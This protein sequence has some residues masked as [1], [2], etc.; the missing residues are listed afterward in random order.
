M[1]CKTLIDHFHI[2]CLIPAGVLSFDGRRWIASRDNFLFQV[3]SLAK[4]MK[5]RYLT[6]IEQKVI[7]LTLPGNHANLTAKAWQKQWIV[8]AKKPFAGPEQVLSYLGRYTHKIAISNHRIQAIDNNRVVFTYKD[9][10]DNNRTRIME[11]PA[12]EF[13]RRF[14]LHVLPKRFMKIRYYGFLAN[15]CK[16]KAVRLIRRLI[17]KYMEIKTIL[18]ETTRDKILRLT[19]KD[20]LLCPH[21]RRGSMRYLAPLPAASG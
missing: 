13:I 5:K 11:L 17:G 1:G 19:G 6:G 7:H 8:Y 21:C 16:R 15:V 12:M 3:N 20:I 9:R 10:S 2:H 18:K 14:L 4:E